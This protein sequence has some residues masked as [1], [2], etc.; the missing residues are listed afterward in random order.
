MSELLN[1][2]GLSA[3]VVLYTVLL[4]MV[5]R[6][7]PKPVGGARFD[8][9]LL[10]TAV[11]GL[12]WNLC[13]LPAYELPKLGVPGPFPFL[14][15][16]GFS[17]L[18]FLPAVVVHSVLRGRRAGL[19][20][21]I[22]RTLTVIAYGVSATAA[23]LHF[24][25]AWIDAAVP[26]VLAM[27]T[28]TYTFVALIVPVAMAT[29]GQ[30]GSRRALWVAALATFAVSALHLSNLHSGDAS[31]PVELIGH[32]ASL[33]LAFAILY[34]DYPFALADLFLK[35]ALV[36]LALLAV[37]FA[38]I[39]L[40]GQYSIAFAE[41]GPQQVS[42]VVTLWVGT[43]LLYPV[44]RRSTAWFVDSILLARPDYRQLRA[45]VIRR[46]EAHDDVARLLT[47]LCDQLRPALSARRVQW[48]EWIGGADQSGIIAQTDGLLVIVAT[49]DAPRYAIEVGEVT[50]GRRFLSDDLATLDALSAAAARRIDGIRITNERY[51]REIRDQELE[52]LATQAELRTLRAQLN[53]HFLFN[54]LTTIGHLI[55]AAPPRA[56]ETLLRL[57]SLLRAVLRSEGEYTTLGREMEMV[58]AYLDIERA[59]F[60]WRLRTELDVAPSL[61]GLR[62][63]PLVLQPIVENAVKH[64]ISR[65]RQGGDVRVAARVER[66]GDV[67]PQ[68][69]LTVT[70]TG[71]GVSAEELRRGR[72]LGVGLQN[73][74][75]RLSCQYGAFASLRITSEPNA[76]TT[77][78]IRLPV[79][80][81]TPVDAGVPLE[82]AAR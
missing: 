2:V 70:D 76:G 57:T 14:V 24:R 66:R 33:P 42:L 79:R 39:A 36:L 58:A 37:A 10:A 7:A 56:L 78:E 68:L 50:G 74:E 21:G 5:I 31:W 53:P 63:P 9:L 34:Q 20:G 13:A 6:N 77:V 64:G 11:L 61:A 80:Q 35:R 72:L 48:Q 69:V 18:G 27:R 23:T 52:K 15:A 82:G 59:R 19:R 67:A 71:A 30:P 75:R 44:I 17:A 47:D 8:P 55:Q 38:T 65:Q 54:A 4:V 81:A 26:S 1:L 51:E 28:L 60:E 32:H 16:I 12:V 46:I 73:V 25:A 45:S 43:A 62:V 29:R 49:A 41:L 3:G 40:F 22:R